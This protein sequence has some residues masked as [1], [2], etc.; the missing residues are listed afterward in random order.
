LAW[1]H[2]GVLLGPGYSAIAAVLSDA[3]T[4]FIDHFLFARKS[5]NHVNVTLGHDTFI[6]E[7]LQ[8]IDDDR[9]T[10]WR[11]LIYGGVS[12]GGDPKLPGHRGSQIVAVTGPNALIQRLEATVFSEG[13][14]ATGPNEVRDDGCVKADISG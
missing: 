14:S 3:G 13:K 4:E 9:L 2:W 7:G 6:Y 1:H 8:A 10:A 5:R 12:F 11:F